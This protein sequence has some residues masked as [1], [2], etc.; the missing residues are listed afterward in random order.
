LQ[1]FYDKYHADLNKIVKYDRLKQSFYINYAMK[2]KLNYVNLKE[3]LSSLQFNWFELN[4][5]K[6]QILEL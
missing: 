6:K 3:F 2:I 4:V 5:F 1:H